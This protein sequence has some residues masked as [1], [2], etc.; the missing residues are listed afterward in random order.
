MDGLQECF[1]CGSMVDPNST[2]ECSVCEGDGCDNC[3]I[4][5]DTIYG[6][7]PRH[8]DCDPEDE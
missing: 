3:L 8:K 2:Q 4:S 1:E 5:Q 6:P 7:G